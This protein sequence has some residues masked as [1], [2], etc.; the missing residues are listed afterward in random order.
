ML[1]LSVKLGCSENAECGKEKLK[2]KSTVRN[3]PIYEDGHDVMKLL[4]A[5]KMADLPCGQRKYVVSCLP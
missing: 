3:I 5:G 4:L 1:H 2:V